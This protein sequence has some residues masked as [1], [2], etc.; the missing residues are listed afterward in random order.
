M[1]P[2]ADRVILGPTLVPQPLPVPGGETAPLQ[3][4]PTRSAPQEAKPARGKITILI[5]A[6][7]EE[8]GIGETLRSLPLA[9]LQAQG[10]ATDVMV[11]DGAS[12]DRTREIA[13]AWGATVVHQVAP[14][15]GAAVRAAKPLLQGDYVIMLDADA[16]YPADAIPHMADLLA[17]G[18]ADVVMG[19]RFRGKIALGAMGRANHVGNA[20]LSLVASVLYARRCS[21][22]C[23]G[24]WG[25]RLEVLQKLPLQSR[26]FELE[27]ELFGRSARAKV[28]LREVGVDYLPR[29]GPTKLSRTRDGVRIARCLLRTRFSRPRDVPLPPAVLQSAPVPMPSMGSEGALPT[30]TPS[31]GVPP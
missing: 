28:R 20:L 10:F 24:L 6:K 16:T 1:M 26:G 11:L 14:G 5:P 9:T 4:T 23:T 31:P 29:K 27:A 25:F 13:L 8:H 19:S 18:D 17:R 22:V 2:P 21:D 12:S 7:N 3:S 15:K 30:P